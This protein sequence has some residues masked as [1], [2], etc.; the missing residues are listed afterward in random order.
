MPQSEL[1]QDERRAEQE[2][3]SQRKDC[4]GDGSTSDRFAEST[5]RNRRQTAR[6]LPPSLKEINRIRAREDSMKQDDCLIDLRA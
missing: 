1:R 2:R 5:A 4:R 3:R 6:D